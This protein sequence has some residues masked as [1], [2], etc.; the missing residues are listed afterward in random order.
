MALAQSLSPPPAW[1]RTLAGP[2]SPNSHEG[3]AA[4]EACGP[5]MGPGRSHGPDGVCAWGHGSALVTPR[6]P[7]LWQ[8][9]PP[10]P[11]TIEALGW[12]LVEQQ[13]GCIM[14]VTTQGSFTTPQ[15]RGCGIGCGCKNI[16]QKYTCSKEISLEENLSTTILRYNLS[17][18]THGK[19]LHKQIIYW[20]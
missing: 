1:V 3:V 19:K 2:A 9:P 4:H 10:P 20:V 17:I 6:S 15:R 7:V 12:A 11:R 8:A 18:A 5:L 14:L 16:H 13:P